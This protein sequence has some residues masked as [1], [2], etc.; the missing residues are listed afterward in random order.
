MGVRIRPCG[1]IELKISKR[2]SRCSGI[3]V[4]D[5]HSHRLYGLM[6]DFISYWYHG[7]S[8]LRAKSRSFGVNP[9]RIVH[10]YALMYD[11][12]TRG[13]IPEYEARPDIFPKDIGRSHTVRHHMA[14]TTLDMK[15]RPRLSREDTLKAVRGVR[16]DVRSKNMNKDKHEKTV[17]SPS[18]LASELGVDVTDDMPNANGAIHHFTEEYYLSYL[19][20]YY[21]FS[22][23]HNDLCSI[24]KDHIPVLVDMITKYFDK[25][26]DP[27]LKLRHIEL[28]DHTIHMNEL[29][30]FSFSKVYVQAR[31]FYSTE[32]K[33]AYV[34]EF[35]AFSKYPKSEEMDKMISELSTMIYQELLKRDLDTNARLIRPDKSP[36]VST[37][38]TKMI[39]VG[40]EDV[41]DTKI[42]GQL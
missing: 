4:R 33:E 8:L 22:L 2:Y 14:I 28:I 20:K 12:K 29:F 38:F 36:D 5:R 19:T 30:L 34:T 13:K 27:K 40:R 42:Y 10:L 41:R 23:T 21:D 26:D 3:P 18:I 15:L 35:V 16:R 24:D 37:Q 7:L 32:P 11:F 1:N 6:P 31:I 39:V 17:R 25:Y 9:F